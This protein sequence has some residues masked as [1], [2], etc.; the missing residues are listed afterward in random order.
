[1]LAALAPRFGERSLEWTPYL[2]GELGIEPGV[3]R[4][5]I[6]AG[7]IRATGFLYVGERLSHEPLES[8]G[9]AAPRTRAVTARRPAAGRGGPR[10]PGR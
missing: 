4:A 9:P 8:A 6:D 5:A 10:R 3:E 7:A 2:R 1:M